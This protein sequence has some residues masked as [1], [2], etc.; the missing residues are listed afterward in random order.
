MH[1]RGIHPS[2]G[3]L[4]IRLGE[5]LT[6]RSLKNIRQQE[7][8]EAKQFCWYRSQKHRGQR[9]MRMNKK[10]GSVAYW[11]IHR[12]RGGREGKNK[13]K[14]MPITSIRCQY[15]A[16][17]KERKWSLSGPHPGISSLK[18]EAK[19]ILGGSKLCEGTCWKRR[20][21]NNNDMIDEGQQRE[22]HMGWVMHF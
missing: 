3:I 13:R 15:C 22:K 4:G 19:H 18:Q 10:T 12:K 6:K 21:Q 7:R 1:Y 8:A 20:L 14:P 16:A 5:E 9:Q 11:A 17:R 2:V